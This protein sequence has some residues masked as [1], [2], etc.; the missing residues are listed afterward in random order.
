[1]FATEQSYLFGYI[2][3][4]MVRIFWIPL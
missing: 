3:L 4:A 1:M 2:T